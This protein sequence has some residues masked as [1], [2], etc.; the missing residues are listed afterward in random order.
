MNDFPPKPRPEIYRYRDWSVVLDWP[1]YENGRRAL[2]L[3]DSETGEQIC[4]ATV[5]VPQ[6]FLEDDCAFIKNY[7]ENAGM[8]NWLIVNQLATPTGRAVR[9]GYVELPEVRWL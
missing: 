8:L 3:L 9:S 1:T 6:E 4:V 5:N 7:S 2:R